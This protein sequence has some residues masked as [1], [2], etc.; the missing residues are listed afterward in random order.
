M[1]LQ[2]ERFWT[3]SNVVSII[4]L[5]L[6]APM[7]WL[8]WHD[9]HGGAI[10]VAALAAAT[11]WIDGRLARATGTVSEWGKVLDPLADK[12]LVGTVVIIMVIKQM[13]PLWFVIAIVLRDVLILIG[14]II[15]ERRTG[16]ITPSIMVGKLA[17]TAIAATGVAGI[18]RATA[19]VQIG[20]GLSTLLMAV[21]LWQY[22][23]RLHG[24]LR[25]T[26]AN[27]Q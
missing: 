20:I 27:T 14:G 8:L 19:F 3:A 26:Q 4:R 5:F 12:V 24:I 9:D 18:M 25:Q 10:I 7:A 23:K 17:V 6:T 16:K 21:S 1:M 11:D 15:A 13:L 22:A 2:H